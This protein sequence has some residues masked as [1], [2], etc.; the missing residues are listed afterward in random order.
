M[1]N[2]GIIFDCDGT[3]VDSLKF[4][5]E[6][7]NYALSKVGESP[8]TEIEI[9]KYFGAAADRILFRLIGNEEKALK[10]F[11]FYVDHQTQLAEHMNLHEGIRELL[12]KLAG[13]KVP[14]AVVTG[15]HT[16][17]LEV[18]LRPHKISHY[19]V[20]LVT[21]NHLP[22]S[23]PAPDGILLA[24]DRMN[25]APRDTCYVGDSTMDLEAAHRAG[26]TAIAALWDSMVNPDEM[27]REHPRFLAQ[28][29]AD[30]WTAYQK[31]RA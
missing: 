20:T 12:D 31:L 16:R 10:A 13:E 23:K 30:V 3:L 25:L 15:R 14:M 24:A 21:D 8:R 1:N 5:F 26:A 28:T 22:L 4:A 27:R 9:K 2:Y 29:P 7:F 19:F 17:D 18:I 11:E 6:S